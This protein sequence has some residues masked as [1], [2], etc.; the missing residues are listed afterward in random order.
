MDERTILEP[1]P[2][3]AWANE[4]HG[5]GT[6]LIFHETEEEALMAFKENSRS[7]KDKS[8]ILFREVLPHV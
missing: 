1:V 5:Y 6:I 7:S 3:E 8:C 4:Y 2:R